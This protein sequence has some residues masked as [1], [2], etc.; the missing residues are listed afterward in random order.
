MKSARS[1]L[2]VLPRL[3]SHD[4]D[5][6]HREKPC[7]CVSAD[8]Q[9]VA[10]PINPPRLA[11]EGQLARRPRKHGRIGSPDRFQP[12][13]LQDPALGTCLLC[14][15]RR[16]WLT[17]TGEPSVSIA[18]SCSAWIVAVLLGG[19]LCALIIALALMLVMPLKR[20]EP[21]VIRVDN[22]TGVVDV[23]PVYAG[24]ALMPEVFTRYLLTHYVTVCERFDFATAESDYEECGAFHS[25][26]R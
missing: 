24:G 19:W 16:R 17:L 14:G 5:C 7:A 1:S 3:D 20:V 25:A 11:L 4:G 18:V 22:S 12:M 15:R 21:F 26:Q 8:A 2:L 9:S 10:R 13:K 6:A 23:V